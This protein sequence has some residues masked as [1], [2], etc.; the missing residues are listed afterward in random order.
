MSDPATTLQSVPAARPAG[1]GN[2][3]AAIARAARATGVDFSYLL[4]QARVESGLDPQARART[5]SATGLFQFIDQT[6]L[7]TLDRHGE[8]LG[9]G[10][11]ADAISTSGGRARVDD[12]ALRG[13]ILA[14]RNDPEIASLMAGALAGDNREAL[15]PVLGREPDHAELYLA[16]FLGAEGS[17][18]LLSTLGHSPDT[19][20]AAILPQAARAN[21][22]IFFEQSG[23]PRS[24]SGV[25]DVVRDKVDRA[26]A[27]GGAMPE[28]Y[29]SGGALTG[30]WASASLPN[31]PV[32]TAPPRPSM[33]ATLEKSFGLSDASGQAP[34]GLA[35]IRRAYARLSAFGL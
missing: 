18:R 2:T 9:L 5:S 31:A 28:G 12:P 34:A 10:H 30:Q 29:A 15:L 16:H 1:T 24:V 17:A 33:A 32:P 21:R 8:R 13:Q 3:Q 23:A 14:L 4:A 19:P 20:A 26:M 35:H 27:Q 11:L 6:W 22:A 7:S 25:M